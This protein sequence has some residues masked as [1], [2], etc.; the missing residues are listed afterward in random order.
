MARRQFLLA[1]AI[2]AAAAAAV[3][4][5][6]LRG[7]FVYDDVT[8]VLQNEWIQEG[9]HLDE[10]LTEQ[11]AAFDPQT[12]TSFY[13][14][15][16]HL[17]YRATWRIAGP[18][19]W[20]FHLVNGLF[21]V[22]CSLLAAVVAW[23]LFSRWG[24][25]ASPERRLDA[26]LCAGLIFATHPVHAEAVAWIAGITDL[27]ATLFVLAAAAF[28]LAPPRP[29][30]PSLGLAA[31]CFFAAT[32]CKE[33]A[34]ALPL[35]LAVIELFPPAGVT[36]P[37]I[38]T[39]L[40]RLA[41]I[42]IAG[43]VA[44]GLRWNALGSLAPASRAT[45]PAG[46]LFDAPWL[47]VQ[48]LAKLVVPVGLNV[49]HVFAPVTG[50]ADPRALAGF[51]TAAAL[52]A[53]AW[54]LR[55]RPIVPVAST[56]IVAPLLPALYVPALGESVLAERYLYLP[57]LGLGLL[58]GWV[59][60]SIPGTLPRRAVIAAI[61]LALVAGSL[62]RQAVWRTNLTLWTEAARRAPSSAASHE[63][64]CFA[65]IEARQFEAALVSC[66]RALALDPAR[67]DARINS[68]TAL[69][70]L[71]RFDE[72]LA[73]FDRALARRPNSPQ[74]LTGRGYALGA[75]GRPDLAVAS[76][77]AAL[78]A[79][80]HHAEAFNGLGVTYA[81]S[82]HMDEA[83]ENLRLAVAAAP[84]RSDYAANL[85]GAERAQAGR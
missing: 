29:R 28:Y 20:A 34:F 21:H 12:R 69:L 83:V 43:V 65:R 17:I 80:P 49:V 41:P 5:P 33:N 58:A 1:L 46:W 39:V 26:T 67:D 45:T 27:S 25:P 79:D 15:G 4:A 73:A 8:N 50:A 55:R 74:A 76:F 2:V 32:L 77:R 31:T 14:P 62:V 53:A 81:R 38:G 16:M 57:V 37:R 10:M 18:Q 75:T 48:Y 60:A 24:D 23:R 13:R 82:G 3:A 63:G 51:A 56:W 7:G 44:L 59:I 85:A 9:G 52:P 36:G 70:E 54:L 6:T 72:A 11:V 30:V 68:G 64:L 19:P 66:Q 78:A 22:A 35:V 84:G 40:R 42:A 71:G 61:A 47:L